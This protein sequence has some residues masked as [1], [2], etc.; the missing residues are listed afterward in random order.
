MRPN[1]K[2]P[3]GP[4]GVSS[5]SACL[6]GLLAMCLAVGC[7]QKDQ[8]RTYRIAKTDAEVPREAPPADT[9]TKPLAAPA[10]PSGEP[11]DRMLGAILPGPD[12]AWF[13]KAV[14]PKESLD[15]SA[16]AIAGFLESVRFD[17]ARPAWELPEGWSEEAGRSMRLATLKVPTPDDAG[18][19]V[20]R[21]ETEISVIGLPLVGDWDA[22]V[23]DNVN[24]WRK[25]LKLPPTDAAGLA[26]ST[27]PLGG[28]VESAVLVDL[29]GWFAGGGMGGGLAP[30]A[31][32]GRSAAPP[33]PTSPPPAAPP[34][35]RQLKS[36]TP[37][38]W[39]ADDK[40]N[41]IRK[42]S[43][44][45]PGGAEVTGFVFPAAGMMADPLFNAN[46]WR[47]EIGLG[48]TTGEQLDDLTETLGLLGSEG[49]YFEF[50]GEEE[51]T[52]VAMVEAEGGV[53]FFKIR[54]PKDEVA[55]QRKT[56][57]EWLDSLAL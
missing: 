37:D 39:T 4:A 28:K 7:R 43:L 11:T 29:D 57:R 40:A 15:A 30:F 52:S 24:R 35:G 18:V 3:I 55:A 19:G 41:S 9:P 2:N 53:W 38:G 21:S 32:G 49:S 6:L 56:F 16:E 17:S 20:E 14:G 54:G 22:Q 1:Q 23:L 45:T 26:D 31:G 44:K 33:A 42:V 27:K 25:Q 10:P 8:I 47:G 46:R 13:F 48:P 51:A 12:Q 34:A 36:D 50:V 5:G